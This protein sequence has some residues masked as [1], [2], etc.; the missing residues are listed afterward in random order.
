MTCA[1]RHH[2]TSSR[3]E[4]LLQQQGSFFPRYIRMLG[5]SEMLLS[6]IVTL[7]TMS[8]GAMPTL[9]IIA[10]T[11][12]TCSYRANR[13]H[14]VLG[15]IHT[16]RM[17]GHS[18]LSGAHK[19]GLEMNCFGVKILSASCLASCSVAIRKFHMVFNLLAGIFHPVL[20]LFN[21]SLFCFPLTPN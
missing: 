18:P 6:V 10:E 4:H 2:T 9:I 14:P 5:I 17:Y 1:L 13:P 19:F 15:D 16:H 7:R 8:P 12:S 3:F 20:R 21:A 11:S